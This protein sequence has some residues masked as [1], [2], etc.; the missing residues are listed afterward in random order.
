MAVDYDRHPKTFNDLLASVIG[1]KERAKEPDY[2]PLVDG[3]VLGVDAMQDL[4][5]IVGDLRARV[6]LLEQTDEA[7]R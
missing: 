6:A 4:I 1:Q 3:V 2:D 5:E 7:G